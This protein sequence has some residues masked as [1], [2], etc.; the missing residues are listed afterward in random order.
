[1][2]S[3]L[4][5]SCFSAMMWGKLL[6]HFSCRSFRMMRT[7]D[8]LRMLVFPWYFTDCA[9]SSGLASWLRTTS[10]TWTMFSSVR[11]LRCL[12]MPWRLSTVPVCLNFLSNLLMLLVVFIPG[13]KI[14]SSTV[15]HYIHSTDTNCFIRILSSLL[16]TTFTHNAVTLWRL[17]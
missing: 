7:T 1:V 12:S 2:T 5:T 9:V 3:F 16:K 15:S 8:D 13:P 4:H 11:A 6:K 17:G 14:L 10:F